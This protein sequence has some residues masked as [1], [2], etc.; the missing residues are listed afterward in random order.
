[1]NQR[2]QPLPTLTSTAPL[3]TLDMPNE[4]EVGALPTEVFE[5][6]EVL[7]SRPPD[8]LP[9]L[10]ERLDAAAKPRHIWTG[11]LRVGALGALALLLLVLFS[12]LERPVS[13]VAAGIH[14]ATQ[15]VVTTI[16]VFIT[17]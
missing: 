4:G 15:A 11:R 1:M 8:A 13:A 5:A 9:R 6:Q 10:N 7:L 3:A 14:D 17:G 12:P 2:T 16:K